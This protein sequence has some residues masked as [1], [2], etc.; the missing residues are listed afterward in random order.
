M[1]LLSVLFCFPDLFQKSIYHVRYLI[2]EMEDFRFVGK[3]AIL[4]MT[5]RWRWSIGYVRF[6]MI[7]QFFLVGGGHWLWL[8]SLKQVARYIV[9]HF[10][11]IYHEM[12]D[13]RCNAIK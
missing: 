7:E 13:E 10:Y 9:F 6:I 4:L 12:S 8:S 5:G 2:K 3:V 1:S 11:F